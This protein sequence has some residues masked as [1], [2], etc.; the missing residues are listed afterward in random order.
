MDQNAE[1]DRVAKSPALL[2]IKVAHPPRSPELTLKDIKLPKDPLE[3]E[4]ESGESE[5]E[6]KTRR[7]LQ[8]R[9]EQ[10]K[11]VDILIPRNGVNV[12]GALTFADQQMDHTAHTLKGPAHVEKDYSPTGNSW[13]ESDIESLYNK[14]DPGRY[15]GRTKK[16]TVENPIE[17][18][19][20]TLSNVPIVH[21]NTITSFGDLVQARL[22]QSKALKK[23][24]SKNPSV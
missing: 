3:T 16:T 7:D 19:T 9:I 13:N 4:N 12:L 6:D 20:Q 5:E 10:M 2:P 15:P 1:T 8:Q 14:Y 18:E 22:I 11:P 23:L 21:T 24:N 17:S